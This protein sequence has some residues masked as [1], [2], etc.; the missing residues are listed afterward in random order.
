MS[1]FASYLKAQTNEEAGEIDESD[2]W[3]KEEKEYLKLNL[4]K[5]FKSPSMADV[6][7]MQ[8][9]NRQSC[10]SRLTKEKWIIYYTY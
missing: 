3:N 5:F 2:K 9:K 4:K 10:Y 6:V 1:A 7:K 8:K